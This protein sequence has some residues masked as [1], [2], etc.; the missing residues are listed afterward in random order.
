MNK[1]NPKVL[2]R[3][4]WTKVDIINKE[5]HFIITEVNFDEQQT[6]VRCVIEAVM[7]LQEYEID[8]RELKYDYMWKVGW[9]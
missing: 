9:Q 7:T 5:K 6:V 1:V 8:W 3:S 2:M 4:K